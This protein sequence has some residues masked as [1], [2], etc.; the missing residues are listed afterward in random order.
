[1]TSYEKK[2]TQEKVF[3]KF[4]GLYCSQKK[5]TAVFSIHMKF[6]FVMNHGQASI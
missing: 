5:L 6:C 3:G 4:A 1:M 2:C